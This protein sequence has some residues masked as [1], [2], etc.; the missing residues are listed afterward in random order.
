V[1]R[2]IQGKQVDCQGYIVQRRPMRETTG[3]QMCHQCFE[4]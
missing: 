2:V 3:Y 1:N 4:N